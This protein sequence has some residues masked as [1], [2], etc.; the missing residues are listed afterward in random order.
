MRLHYKSEHMKTI[1]WETEI[2]FFFFLYW[3]QFYSFED[4]WTSNELN[5]KFSDKYRDVIL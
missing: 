5:E 4:F 2:I 3:S 1:N